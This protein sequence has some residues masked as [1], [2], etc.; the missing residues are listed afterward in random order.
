M[1]KEFC[2]ENFM[3]IEQAIKNGVKRNN[4]YDNIA[5]GGTTLS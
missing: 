2:G 1:I 5:V 4:L 3:N